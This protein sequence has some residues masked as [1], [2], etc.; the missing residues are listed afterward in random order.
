MSTDI[1]V[2]FK[3]F[4]FCYQKGF[5][6]QDFLAMEDPGEAAIAFAKVY[7]RCGNSYTLRANCARQA[8]EFFTAIPNCC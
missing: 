3:T 8:F 5:T 7:E 1:A 4:G 2:E 6:Y